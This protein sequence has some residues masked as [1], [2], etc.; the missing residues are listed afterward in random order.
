MTKRG[1]PPEK[2]MDHLFLYSRVRA[3][4][5]KGHTLRNA[6]RLVKRD[7]YPDRSTEGIRQ[8]YMELTRTWLKPGARP[9]SDGRIHAD[10]Y[11]W[12]PARERMWD[13]YRRLGSY[14]REQDKKEQDKN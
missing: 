7:H 12:S 6:C 4:M 14:F 13:F 9:D 5:E 11:T 10:Q 2:K 1:R 8:T 3:Y